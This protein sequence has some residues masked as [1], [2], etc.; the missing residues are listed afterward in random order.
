MSVKR[1]AATILVSL[2]LMAPVAGSAPAQAAK[3]SPSP[4]PSSQPTPPPSG[5]ARSGPDY[6]AKQDA[7]L[8]AQAA[9]DPELGV[10]PIDETGATGIPSFMLAESLMA[11]KGLVS[12]VTFTGAQNAAGL[13]T[14]GGSTVGVREGA[15][16]TNGDV[17][18][19]L[20]PNQ[21]DNIT[22]DNGRPGDAALN[23][24]V[25]PGTTLD[26]TIL[27]FDLLPTVSS[28]SFNFSFTSDEYNEFA[29]STY[30][31]VFGFFVD[32][33]N[34]AL[35]PDAQTRIS[36]N[37]INGGNPIGVDAQHPE[38]YINNDRSD[39]GGAFN[40]EMDGMTT[41]LTATSA[42]TVGSVVHIKLAIADTGDRAYDS[43]VFIAAVGDCGIYNLDAVVAPN[44]TDAADVTNVTVKYDPRLL[45]PQNHP[46]FEATAQ[47]IA[48]EVRKR[49]DK[50]VARY[51]ALGYITSPVVEIQIKC[52][53][54]V[55]PLNF[56]EFHFF[57]INAEIVP[58]GS[59][60][61]TEADNT[62]KLRAS[63]I[64]SEFKP[65]VQANFPRD[66]NGNAVGGW[67][68]ARR[69][70]VSLVDHEIFHTLQVKN[71]GDW[72][73][74][75]DAL[76]QTIEGNRLTME[77]GAV[78]AQ[79]ILVDAD[80]LGIVAGN[81]IAYLDQ[82]QP[83]FAAQ[84]RLNL[85]RTEAYY[86]APAVFQYWGERYGPPAA[87]REEQVL[88]WYMRL[89]QPFSL[90]PLDPDAGF[91]AMKEVLA[92]VDIYDALRDFYIAAYV[93]RAANVA[94]Q[95]GPL[96]IYR[97]LDEED[98]RAAT[99]TAAYP[100]LAT[101]PALDL[102]TGSKTVT[103]DRSDPVRASGPEIYELTL[104]VNA[105]KVRVSI[106][107]IE[108]GGVGPMN[109]FPGTSPVHI[110]FVKAQN[111]Q[112]DQRTGAVDV[113]PFTLGPRPDQGELVKTID[114][115]GHSRLGVIVVASD[116]DA[117]FTIRFDLETG[118]PDLS[119]V[120]PTPTTPAR[121]VAGSASQGVL[122]ST[123]P[124]IAGVPAV[125]LDRSSFTARIGTT[126]A[127]V[128]GV[129]ASGNRWV[130][131]L[132]PQTPLAAGTYSLSVTFQGITRTVNA[133]VIV[134]PAAAALAATTSVRGELFVTNEGPAGT[135]VRVALML[136][137][138]RLPTLNASVTTAITDPAGR[139]RTFV[140]PDS[141]ANGDT[142]QNDGVY[143]NELWATDVAGTYSVTVTATGT[144][145]SGTP[146]NVSSSAT[147]TL[148]A[149]VDTDGDGIVDAAEA[150]FGL[151]PTTADDRDLDGDGLLLAAELRAGTDPW[152][153][154][155]DGGG[156]NDAS[157][158]AATRDPLAVADD[159]PV[160]AAWFD[161]QPIDGARVFLTAA[162]RDG[163][164]SIEVYRV[165]GGPRVLVGT[166]QGGGGS[167]TD[168]PIPVG[169]YGYEAVIVGGGG[170]RS[171]AIRRGP[172]T[173]V[174][175]A[176]IPTA[177]FSVAG[178]RWGTNTTSVPVSFSELS[179]PVVSMRIAESTAALVAAPWIPF[180][181]TPTFVIGSQAGRHEIVAQVRDSAGLA[182][183]IMSG[184]IDLDQIAPTSSAS[185]L[186]G[187]S[188][189][190]SVSVPFSAA[191]QGSFVAAVSL[192]ARTRASATDP[193]SAWQ[194]AGAS[195]TSPI[196]YVAAAD[197][198]F[199]FHTVAADGSGNVEGA[200]AAADASTVIDT[201]LPTSAAQS[202]PVTTS[203]SSLAVPWTGSDS[204][205]GIATV[206]LWSRYRATST[207]AWGPWALATSGATSPLTYTFTQGAGFYEFYTVGVDRAANR[208]APPAV[209]DA[210]TQKTAGDT[211]P[212]VS[213]SGALSTTYTTN[214]VTVPYTA[215]DNAS[216]V[217]SVE[218]WVRSRVNEVKPFTAWTLAAT[219][220]SSPFT[221]TFA[222]GDGTY[223]FYTVA[224]DGVGNREAPPASADSSTRRDAVNDPPDFAITLSATRSCTGTC[225][226]G[227]GAGSVFLFGEGTAVDDRSNVTVSWR[228]Y[229]V[230]SNG[231][232]RSL[233]FN[234]KTIPGTGD[235]PIENFVIYDTRTDAGYAWYDVEIKAAVSGASTTRTIRVKIVTGN[236][237]S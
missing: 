226:N 100:P 151:S 21:F 31:D 178:G 61:F 206:E 116:D 3:P 28:V 221:Y 5:V 69:Y 119:I 65:I 131:V 50:A 201:G 72:A 108:T 204:P 184:Q 84:N 219:R 224:I 170:A 97:F 216:G 91:A 71:I 98:L 41:V 235:Q 127:T 107:A 227:S 16:L 109:W 158:V 23:A 133:A 63:R 111:G 223:E 1:R 198:L 156:E 207:G 112:P 173:V 165:S 15:L 138:P 85:Q 120:H 86:N 208:E 197:G 153:Q 157:E 64:E 180:D 164:G 126:P 162:T 62:I 144:D 34:I 76:V 90:N 115:A 78:L 160:G 190:R 8:S 195:S 51:R 32:G 203:T 17:R 102:A 42:V 101:Q 186:P 35:L 146:F 237:A 75:V 148:T 229:G 132:D 150:R 79:D 137:E 106:D 215:S 77:S 166:I 182:S 59:D 47:K 9:G 66:V 104:P 159:G 10:T 27:E 154:D 26:A 200:P 234:F 46:D 205:A 82:I 43:A 29:N 196:A 103:H 92:P 135:P 11:G 129:V 193:W 142:Q 199:E 188:P 192:Y 24:L 19:V 87:S 125:G 70:W 124:T 218:L 233:L 68:T 176:T 18:N 48:L 136:S 25:A 210:T 123:L 89:I 220:T 52:D 49:A 94:G 121:V 145:S 6:H 130:M 222:N 141:G 54:G 167:L 88:D 55:S 174:N 191:D 113:G 80:N 57:F 60:G 13:F 230:A 155:T 236:P 231:T 143:G 95:A 209:A 175:D 81:W 56:D 110:A 134:D 181:P 12:N 172:I 14:G 2:C 117:A 118:A 37:S 58:Q 171:A 30:N 147:T 45:L 7:G 217:A 214:T 187:Y 163:S 40:T 22:T 74:S 177:H 202:L 128:T 105:S 114:V 213:A 73:A 67:D 228:L 149:K 99:P 169:G 96:S 122:V 36:V 39:G 189:S 183:P 194:L 38:F 179:E 225:T 168:G 211:T 93:R 83:W 139:T 232:S 53:I 152:R 140:V 185:A 212:P 33:Q 44:A 161:A 4:S 20:G